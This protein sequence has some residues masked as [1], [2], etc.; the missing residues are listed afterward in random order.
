[1]KQSHLVVTSTPWTIISRH[2][3]D[4]RGFGQR[5]W[6][7]AYARPRTRAGLPHRAEADESGLDLPASFFSVQVDCIPR[8]SSAS[9]I[10]RRISAA[11]ADNRTFA[12]CAGDGQ[13]V[14]IELRTADADKRR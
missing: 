11:P 12:A 8:S 10:M 2:A 4:A 3:R 1:M 6:S 14:R 5:L 13:V 7:C 9:I